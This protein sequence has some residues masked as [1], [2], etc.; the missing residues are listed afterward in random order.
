MNDDLPYYEIR[1]ALDERDIALLIKNLLRII[2][3]SNVH[4][5]GIDI[6]ILIEKTPLK[7]YNLKNV[8]PFIIDEY[9]LI[10]ELISKSDNFIEL[11]KKGL[12]I[13][14]LFEKNEFSFK[15]IID[16]VEG[17]NNEGDIE[18]IYDAIKELT[19]ELRESNR[20]RVHLTILIGR[21][22]LLDMVLK[23]SGKRP[24]YDIT[25][26]FDPDLPYY[27]NITLSQLRLFDN[28]PI[29]EAGQEMRFF[30]NSMIE[31]KDR[32]KSQLKTMVNTKYRDSNGSW[33]S[34]RYSLELDK[35]NDLLVREES[36]L[37]NI[38]KDL[39]DIKIELE[40]FRRLGLLIK[41]P[42]DIAKESEQIK[43]TLQ[44]TE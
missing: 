11:T 36:N 39:Q 44:R 21:F 24:A 9:L 34:E 31:I 23:N 17:K 6:K 40:R 7:A 29:L 15:E 13:T 32:P 10:N 25:C 26:K 1:R 8:V 27:S 28:F 38:H 4:G 37:N 18:K 19:F 35:F 16:I 14:N 22:N 42:E 43:K 30:F 3:N 33:F 2:R 20:P 41:T 12:Q 5:S